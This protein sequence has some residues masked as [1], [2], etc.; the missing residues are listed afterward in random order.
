MFYNKKRPSVSVTHRSSID[1]ESEPPE[2][3]QSV[4]KTTPSMKIIG[5]QFFGPDFDN[6]RGKSEFCFLH[7]FELDTML[8]IS[9]LLKL[10]GHVGWFHV[11]LK[12]LLRGTEII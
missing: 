1:E 10:L 7:F 11:V 5:N 2:T 8:I 4:P 3:P 12:R 9:I 6:V